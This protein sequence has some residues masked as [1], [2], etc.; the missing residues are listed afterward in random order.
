MERRTVSGELSKV[1]YHL[2]RVYAVL[3]PFIFAG[4]LGLMMLGLGESLTRN[5][6]SGPETM[7]WGGV[8]AGISLP[9]WRRRD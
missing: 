5:W 8:L 9:C 1:S 6:D 3:R 7:G 2:G 4:G